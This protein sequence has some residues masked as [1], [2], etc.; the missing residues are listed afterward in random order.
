MPMISVDVGYVD[1]D[2]DLNEFDD[3][4]LISELQAR[5]FTVLDE[6]D[7]L[8]SQGKLFTNTELE[9]LQR[10][11]DEKQPKIGSELY[12]TREKLSLA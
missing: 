12:F 1:V 4:E 8:L 5:G 7:P 10:L 2:V 3:D 11:I 6:D 9:I